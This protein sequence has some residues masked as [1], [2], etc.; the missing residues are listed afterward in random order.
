MAHQRSRAKALTITDRIVYNCELEVCP[1][2]GKELKPC[3]HYTWA[4]TVQHLDRVAYVAS[5][6][7]EC[8]NPACSQFHIRYPSAT[9]QTVALSH[10]TYGLDVIAQIGWWR[11][12]EH[13]SG[14][15]IHERLRSRVQISRRQ[16]DLLIQQYRLLL[17]CAARMERDVLA[18]AVQIHG[19]LIISLDGLE[20]EGAQEQLWVVRE[21]LTDSI[22]AVGWVP[23]VTADSLVSLLTPVQAWLQA[24]GWPVR[25]TVSDK[26]VA[27]RTAVERVWPDVPHQWCQAHYLRNAVQPLQDHDQALKTDLRREVRRG[28]R[29][30]LQQMVDASEGDAFSPSDRERPGG[31]VGD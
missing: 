29:H 5:R 11:D 19:G 20:P 24:A 21:V 16:V 27:L 22:L 6:P 3:R 25:A 9:A 17:A 7:K 14:R 10:G 8:R 13:L 2:C 15:E 28:M 30:R 23:R 4:K 26:Q 18:Q 31:T 12:R 1:A